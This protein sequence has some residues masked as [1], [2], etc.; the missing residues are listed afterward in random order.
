VGI[1]EKGLTNEKRFVTMSYI[2]YDFA[3]EQKGE[4][5]EYKSQYLYQAVERKD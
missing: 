3:T 4:L 2:K 5:E 1:Y